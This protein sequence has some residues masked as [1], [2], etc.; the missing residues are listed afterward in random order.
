LLVAARMSALNYEAFL[1]A[2]VRF[3]S[4]SGFDPG[5]RIN[6]KMFPFQRAIT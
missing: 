4:P 5:E 3:D 1:R 6:Q 2:K